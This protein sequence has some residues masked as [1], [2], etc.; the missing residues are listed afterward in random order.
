MSSPQTLQLP[1]EATSKDLWGLEP[2][3][4]YMVQLRGRGLEPLETTFNTRELGKEVPWGG[5]GHPGVRALGWETPGCPNI[6][7]LCGG[8]NTR[9]LGPEVWRGVPEN[10]HLCVG[11]GFG[12]PKCLN[13]GSLHRGAP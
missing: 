12:I 4:H 3:G 13:N 10:L 6:W 1:P 11:R 9:M 8:G 7:M 2:T 5:R